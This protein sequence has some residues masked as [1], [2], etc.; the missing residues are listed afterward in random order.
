VP[1]FKTMHKSG[2]KVFEYPISDFSSSDKTDFLN[3]CKTMQDN[4]WLKFSK[5]NDV[6]HIQPTPP[7]DLKTYFNG[8]WAEEANR[9]LVTKVLTEYSQNHKLKYKVF[10]DVRLKL[11]D[12]D[13]SNSHDMQLDLVIQI[14]DI[15]YVFETKT[16][17]LG[18]QKWVERAEIFNQNRNRFLTCCMDSSVNPKLF[19]PYRLL[20]LERL[21]EEL[22]VLL[23]YDFPQPVASNT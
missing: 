18:I 2:Y 8:G 14:N 10:W 7:T 23:D 21:E 6:L 3:L 1:L 12:S 15:F 5:S 19:Q 17:V 13:K 16:G 22:T 4:G 20:A 11:I 9:Y